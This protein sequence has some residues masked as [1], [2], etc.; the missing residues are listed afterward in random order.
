LT[1]VRRLAGD[2]VCVTVVLVDVLG[3]AWIVQHVLS[4]EGFLK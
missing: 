3:L 4:L 2:L 1:R